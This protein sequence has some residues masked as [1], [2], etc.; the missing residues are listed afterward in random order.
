MT[1]NPNVLKI[2]NCFEI[3]FCIVKDKNPHI[4]GDTFANFLMVKVTKIILRKTIS[5]QPKSVFFI[6]KKY[7]KAGKIHYYI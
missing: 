3:S 7:L 5:Q 4:I 6:S 1:L 2:K